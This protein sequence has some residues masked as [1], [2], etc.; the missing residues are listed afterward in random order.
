MSERLLAI[1]LRREGL[2]AGL[3]RRM[4][5]DRLQSAALLAATQGLAAERFLLVTCERVELYL[6]GGDVRECLGRWATVLGVPVGALIEWCQALTGAAAAAH[7]LRV[8]AGLESRLVGEPQILQQ[9]R[10]AH[11]EAAAQRSV[12]P[13]LSTL[14][15]RAIHAGKR[16]RREAP[17]AETHGGIARLAVRR[18]GAECGGL[19]DRKVLVLGTGLLARRVVRHLEQERAGRIAVVSRDAE[20]AADLARIVAR[21]DRAIEPWHLEL[22]DAAGVIACTAGEAYALRAQDIPARKRGL[23][24]VIDLGVPR[25]VE[26]AAGQSPGVKLLQLEELSVEGGVAIDTSGAQ[27]ILDIEAERFERWMRA[28]AACDA[29]AEMQRG[30]AGASAE[31]RR[32]IH[33]RI[34]ALKVQPGGNT[35]TGACRMVAS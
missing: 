4:P 13:V 30:S 34:M 29:I 16:V 14:V 2:P 9:V 26:P 8:A 1:S 25:N 19:R 22:V 10:L 6:V 35:P 12:G 31:Q 3:A 11:R 21:G 7:L 33:E 24:C 17:F 32:A 23:L 5:A 20:R 15:Q 18:L 28:R 27:R